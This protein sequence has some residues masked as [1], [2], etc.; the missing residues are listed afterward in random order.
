MSLLKE[1]AGFNKKPDPTIIEL[2]AD[3]IKSVGLN[4]S[5]EETLE[6]IAKYVRSKDHNE[7]ASAMSNEALTDLI[8]LQFNDEDM[9]DAAVK[10]NVAEEAELEK[11]PKSFMVVDGKV[12]LGAVWFDD[13][14]WSAH[15]KSTQKTKH[16]F[17]SKEEAMKWVVKGAHVS[18]DEEAP[19]SAED[20]TPDAPTATASDQEPSMSSASTPAKTPAPVEAR[21]IAHAD[22]YKVVLVDNEQVHI[23]DGKGL[24]RLAMP[25]VIWKQLSR[26]Q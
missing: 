23:I 11:N 16:G 6:K 25:L 7:R 12:Q 9:D 13:G 15:K 14:V 24:T 17:D 2:I 21:T 3:A 22:Q 18:E 4:H 8:K 26:S 5:Y 10:N 19:A 20:A 1:L